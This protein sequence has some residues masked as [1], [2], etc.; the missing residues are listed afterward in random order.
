MTEGRVS[1]F[2]TKSVALVYESCTRKL[3]CQDTQTIHL[4]FKLAVKIEYSS[5]SRTLSHQCF[6]GP[7]SV[8]FCSSRRTVP[9]SDDKLLEVATVP[10]I[11][12]YRERSPL[13]N[14]LVYHWSEF[15]EQ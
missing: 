13:A 2:A 10:F 4:C 11:H 5:S 15:P 6:E 14:S 1:A 12:K 7:E 8:K 3:F 9:N